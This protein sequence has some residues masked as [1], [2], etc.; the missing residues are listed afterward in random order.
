MSLPTLAEGT[1]PRAITA[2]SAR[3]PLLSSAIIRN[4]ATSYAGDG[5]SAISEPPLFAAGENILCGFPV[6]GSSDPATRP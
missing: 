6:V 2:P 5:S 1:Q 3:A 4:S